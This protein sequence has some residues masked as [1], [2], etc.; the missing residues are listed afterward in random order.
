[1]ARA[2]PTLF[3]MRSHAFFRLLSVTAIASALLLS[4]CPSAFSDCSPSSAPQGW[5]A[6]WWTSYK[7]W[8]RGCG[9]TICDTYNQC[10]AS[11]KLPAAGTGAGASTGS[12][13]ASVLANNP[14]TPITNSILNAMPAPGNMRQVFSQ[15]L[16][17]GLLGAL[18]M[19]A[20]EQP[21]TPEQIQAQQEANERA[22]QAEIARQQ[23]LAQQRQ[24]K[25]ARLDKNALD[26]LSLLDSPLN[27]TKP[28]TTDAK[29]SAKCTDDKIP[30]GDF[31][32]HVTVCGGEYNGSSVCCPSGYPKLNECDCQCY[33]NDSN[34]ECSR[35]AACNY[36]ANY[37]APNTTNPGK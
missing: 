29:S 18:E 35:Y 22:Q 31:V 26:Q 34:F 15:G 10:Y 4:F 16:V 20:S 27:Q 32:C 11:C 25:V 36:S 30:D 6:G 37:N 12:A 3:R 28:V 19:S 17:G 1:M 23:Q 13:G 2:P 14:N 5:G 21:L 33:P 7:S 24:E 8:C 9:G